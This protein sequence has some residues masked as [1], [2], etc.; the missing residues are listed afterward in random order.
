MGYDLLMCWLMY[1]IPGMAITEFMIENEIWRT[2]S[3]YLLQAGK[4]TFCD[5]S[6][7]IVHQRG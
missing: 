6:R 4:S 3:R 5:V 7:I 1:E 2:L